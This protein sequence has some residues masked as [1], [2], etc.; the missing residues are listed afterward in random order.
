MRSWAHDR[1][2]RVD[3]QA[4]N[5]NSF[6]FR[7]VLLC[8]CNKRRRNPDQQARRF[9]NDRAAMSRNC[10]E[11]NDRPKRIPS[12]LTSAGD[13]QVAAAAD[14]LLRRASRAHCP[15]RHVELFSQ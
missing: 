14:R 5:A 3:G 9:S 8:N 11:Q 4:E 6:T 2:P 15:V 10:I 12:A 1:K 7:A 13:K